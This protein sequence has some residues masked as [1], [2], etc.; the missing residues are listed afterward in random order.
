MLLA[1]V[2]AMAG[3]MAGGLGGVFIPIPLLGP[4]IGA[5]GGGALGAFAG[6]YAGEAW[7]GRSDEERLVISRGALVGRLLGTVGKLGL[8]AVMVAVTTIAAFVK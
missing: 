5:V 1:M 3:S 7:K 6:A 4:V 8:G 2:G